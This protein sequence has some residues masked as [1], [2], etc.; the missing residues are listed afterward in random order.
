MVEFCR[1]C[2]GMMLPSKKDEKQNGIKLLV[3]NLCDNKKLVS[4]ELADSYTFNKEINHPHGEEFKNLKKME[5]WKRKEI[6][7][8]FKE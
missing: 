3:C 6:Y 7:N 4:E 1:K 8:K 2:G 5:N